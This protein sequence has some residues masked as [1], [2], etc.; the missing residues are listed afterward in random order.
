ME[1]ITWSDKY[2]VNIGS[3]DKQHKKL[4]DIINRLHK[5]MLDKKTKDEMGIILNE[6]ID[7]TVEHFGYEEELFTKYSYPGTLLHKKEHKDLVGKVS[8]FKNEFTAGKGAVS[9]KLLS[10]LKDWL[11][12]HIN[13]TDQKYS[14]FLIEKGVK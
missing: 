2:S 3:I 12:N 8:D 5:A 7:Y 13:G 1:L 6:L 11:I 10:F 9:M 14:D 4:V